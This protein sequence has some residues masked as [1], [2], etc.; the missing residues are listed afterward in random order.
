MP[1]NLIL[2]AGIP[3]TGKTT[4]G[5]LLADRYGYKHIN[6]EE[7]HRTSTILENFDDFCEKN[8]EKPENLVLTWGFSPDKETIDVVNKLRERGFRVFWFDG[9]RKVARQATMRRSDFD[10]NVLQ[11]Q[12]QALDA[13]QVPE[14]I[15]AKVVDVF[16]PEGNFRAGEEVARE[17]G[18]L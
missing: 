5:D 15:G 2:I 6:M 8:L 4:M 3:G 13:W 1:R 11:V 16:G 14:K 9:D 12:M 17:M 18:V 7:D 10:L